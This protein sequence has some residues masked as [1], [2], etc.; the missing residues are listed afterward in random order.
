[1]NHKRYTDR[2]NRA[3]ATVAVFALLGVIGGGAYNVFQLQQLDAAEP[4]PEYT[5]TAEGGLGE[6]SIQEY[7]RT[8]R[9]EQTRANQKKLEKQRQRFEELSIAPSEVKTITIKDAAISDADLAQYDVAAHIDG[10]SITYDPPSLTEVYTA[11]ITVDTTTYGPL[12]LENGKMVNDFQAFGHTW[13]R[14]EGAFDALGNMR[15]GSEVVVTTEDGNSYTFIASS[16]PLHPEKDDTQS[17][18]EHAGVDGRLFTCYTQN[19]AGKQVISEEK[20]TLVPL[21]FVAITTNGKTF[22]TRTLY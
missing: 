22:D 12:G 17:M 16:D 4:S 9:A 5:R 13:S 20:Y 15:S 21:E 11:A 8:A 7:L 10:N 1:M 2:R 18:S 14:G 6:L 19:V 3:P